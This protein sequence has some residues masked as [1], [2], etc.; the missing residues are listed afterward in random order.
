MEQVY[1]CKCETA[2]TLQSPRGTRCRMFEKET[3]SHI[4]LHADSEWHGKTAL[5]SF[6]ATTSQKVCLQRVDIARSDCALVLCT[7]FC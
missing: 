5:K 6:K 3:I 7:G 2:T 1:Q 4:L